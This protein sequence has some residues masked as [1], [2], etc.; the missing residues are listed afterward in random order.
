METP[1]SPSQRASDGINCL[2]FTK[3]FED[4]KTHI[5]AENEH[6]LYLLFSTC[7]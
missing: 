4:E 7:S 3:D 1:L 5:K 2:I 6:S